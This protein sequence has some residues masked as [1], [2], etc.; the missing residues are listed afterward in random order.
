MFK[1]DDAQKIP[2][3]YK[4]LKRRQREHKS[5]FWLYF[6][7]RLLV[8]VLAIIALF[9]GDFPTLTFCVVSLLLFLLP[10]AVE[11]FFQIE[12]PA[13]LEIIILLFI[14]CSQ[15]LGEAAS[16]YVNVP[17]WD[18]ILHT[19]NGFLCAAIGFSL[20]DILNKKKKKITLSPLFLTVLAFCFSMTVGVLW[21][22]FE[23][24]M[25]KVMHTDMQK[26]FLLSTLRTVFL[27]ESR[28]NVVITVKN[29]AK[30]VLYGENGEVLAVIEG[31]FL[32]VGVID[33]MKDLLLNFVGAI[34]F[35]II[36]Y[37]YVL[38]K[39][40]GKFARQFIPT[41]NRENTK[42]NKSDP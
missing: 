22:F 30:T 19:V 1:R 21:E 24:F 28:S 38:N 15:V 26:D 20:I 39:G 25:D 29:I 9:L 7:L 33:T 27:D 23:F 10:F 17:L 31:G 5:T 6:I 11:E 16:F 35:C 4:R 37:C 36:G 42:K 8:A 40:D 18:S 3:L 41:V 32:D 13:T 14:F 2:S 34:V 12:L